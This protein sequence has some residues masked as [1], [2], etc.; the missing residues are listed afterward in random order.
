MTNEIT[1]NVTDSD[2]GA[3]RLKDLLRQLTTQQIRYCI[4][5]LETRTD[6]EAGE[7]IGGSANTIKSWEHKPLIDEAVSL[8][9]YDG[10]LTALEIRRRNLARAMAVKAAGLDSRDERI[11][12]NAA[13]EIIEWELGKANQKTES[14]NSGEVTVKVVRIRD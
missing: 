3:D 6:K 14:K 9:A 7:T 12:Q 2:T 4:A 5:R 8:M 13:T 10:V 11:R 1:P